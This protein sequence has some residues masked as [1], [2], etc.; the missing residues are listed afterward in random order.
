MKL[1]RDAVSVLLALVIFR[2]G[3]MQAQTTV[4]ASEGWRAVANLQPASELRVK[5]TT[6][7]TKKASFISANDDSLTVSEKD[8]VVAIP[9]DTVARIHLVVMRKSA[10]G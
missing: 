5:L 4:V 1:A 7:K 8:Q 10:V 3:V 2:T 6:G 9:R